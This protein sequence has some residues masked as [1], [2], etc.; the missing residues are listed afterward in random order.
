MN[1]TWLFIH[2]LGFT[3]WIGGALS[4]MF[5]GI[6]ARGEDRAGLGAVV[7]AQAA[8]YRM[9]VLPGAALTVLSGLVLTFRVTGAYASANTWLIVMQGTGILAAL[10]VL[11]VDVPTMARIGRIDPTGPHAAAFDELRSRHKV[12]AS[13]AGALALIALLAGAMI[14]Y[15]G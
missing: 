4:A 5:A 9:L 1:R 2:L 11:M 12:I 13:I 6:A 3:V 10:V 7:R 14:R 15:P 8:I